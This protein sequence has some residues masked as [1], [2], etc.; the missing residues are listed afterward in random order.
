MTNLPTSW[1]DRAQ[2]ANILKK[3]IKKQF[4]IYQKEP[5]RIRKAKI[6]QN[7]AYLVQTQSSLIRDEK[8]IEKRL[9]RL[10]DINKIK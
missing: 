10:E 9:Q 4:Q 2:Y 8:N 7:I 6:A 3:I 5:D 1:F